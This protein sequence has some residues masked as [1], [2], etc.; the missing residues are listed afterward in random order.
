[1]FNHDKPPGNERMPM[2]PDALRDLASMGGAVGDEIGPMAGGPMIPDLRNIKREPPIIKKESHGGKEFEV[3]YAKGNP[4]VTREE[5]KK[6]MSMHPGAP[7]PNIVLAVD[8]GRYDITDTIECLRDQVVELRD[9]V[10]IYADIYLPKD[11][12]QKVPLILCWSFF[13]KP[14]TWDQENGSMPGVPHGAM[15]G[16]TNFES[17]DPAY[18]CPNGY[19]VGCVSPRGVGNSEGDVCNFGTQDARDCYDFIEWAAVQEWCSGKIGMCGNS[20]LCMSQMMVAAE[21]PPHLACIAP[22]DGDN[23]LYR[24]SICIGGI[25]T[26]RFNAQVVF[27]I[28][29]HQ[30]VED[31]PATFEKYPYM[32]EYWESKIPKWENVNIPAYC[33]AG[34]CTGHLRGSVEYFRRIPSKKKW[35]RIHREMEWGDFYD[36][37][38]IRDL[39]MFFDRYLKN[40][41]NGWEYTPAVRLEVMDVEDHDF[42]RNRQEESFPVVRTEYRKLYL[43]TDK[44][45]REENGGNAREIV[46]DPAEDALVWEYTFEEDTELIGYLKAHLCV[47]CRGHNNMDL[48]AWATKADQEGDP[49]NIKFFGEVFRGSWGSLRVS[50]RALDERLSTDFNPVQAHRKDEYLEPGQVV[51]VDIEMAPTARMYHAGERLRFELSG[52][53]IVP[54]WQKANVD[55]ATQD[56]GEG[57]HVIHM[58]GAC[59]SYLQIPVVPPKYRHGNLVVR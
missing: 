14:F 59:E 36:P 44:S 2:S 15:S 29:S 11:R 17:A 1:M 9:G 37:A 13:G 10:H 56:N 34:W 8:T 32:N 54:E 40:I 38:N 52:H 5:A 33:A 30:L 25:D 57:M 24:E 12:S 20:A 7:A 53:D 18:W 51:E 27:G 49:L 48:Y 42:D 22:W 16:M 50:R 35:L 28:A 21:Q 4:G 19:A 43:H 39:H 26:S 55:P 47:E 45:L 46:Y 23:D 6:A 58:G 3:C 41:R 31:L